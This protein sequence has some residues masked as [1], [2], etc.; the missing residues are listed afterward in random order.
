MNLRPYQ[1]Q[2]VEAVNKGW[3]EFSR[4][5]VVS[6]TGSGKT[7]CFSHLAK[8]EWQRSQRTLILVDQ[9]ELV[10]QALEKLERTSGIRGDAEKAEFSASHS[11]PVVVSTVQSM[12]RRLD[13]WSKNHFSL[14]IA[15]EADKSVS[16]IWQK[17]LKHFDARTCGFTATP[18]RTDQ[19]ELGSFYEN[20]ACEI[21]LLDLINQGFLSRIKIQMLP[22]PIDLKNVGMARTENGSDYDK[23]QLHEAIEPYLEAVARGIVDH[24]MFRKTMVFLPLIKTSQ[25]F[26]SICQDLGLNAEHIDGESEDRDEKLKRFARGEFDILCNS[27][28][29]TRGYDEP[30]IDCIVMLRPTKSISLYM[31]CVG[32]GTRICPG[33]E[34]LLLLDFLYQ[35]GKNMVCRPAHLVAKTEA[36]AE[37]ITELAMQKTGAIPGDIAEGLQVDLI[38]VSNDAVGQREIALRKRLEEQRNKKS[39]NFEF[40]AAEFAID[41]GAFEAADYEPTMGWETAAV[42][43]A[44]EKLLK[45]AKIDPSTVTCFGHA[46]KLLD[47]HFKNLRPRLAAPKAIGLMKRMRGLSAQVGITDFDN[48]TAAQAGRF[49]KALKERKKQ[50]QMI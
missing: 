10:W 27:A 43:V 22:L 48:V 11:A 3:A 37:I 12:V 31:Q 8:I 17:V 38:E 1:Q 35:S 46:T 50:P 18:W 26:V 13:N 23:N 29:L 7:V 49:F 20:V 9:N 47:L 34:D 21:K 44:Q 24:A 6:P 4:Q 25:K 42:S 19:K 32:R 45:R 16:D 14:V 36:E 41:H 5:L 15:D 30:S 39:N 33:K 2:I 40:S 28:L